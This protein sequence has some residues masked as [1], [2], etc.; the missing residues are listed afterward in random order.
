MEK[1]NFFDEKE[2]EMA[3]EKEENTFGEEKCCPGTDGQTGGRC[4]KSLQTKNGTV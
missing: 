3:K 2:K 1:E 4:K